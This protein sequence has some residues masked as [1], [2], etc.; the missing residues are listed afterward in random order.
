M[1]ASACYNSAGGTP[2]ISSKAIS[3]PLQTV[4]A[5]CALALA[6]IVANNATLKIGLARSAPCAWFTDIEATRMYKYG[7]C[8]LDG[9][10]ID[11]VSPVINVPAL[12][13]KR[14]YDAI[15]HTR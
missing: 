2:T 15:S 6:E 10:E 4:M 1:S 9:S 3:I 13:S 11:H 5:V 12:E 8:V 7:F 14:A